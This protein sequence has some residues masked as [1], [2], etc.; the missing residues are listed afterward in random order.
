M[1]KFTRHKNEKGTA[2]DIQG[3]RTMKDI[4][5]STIHEGRFPTVTEMSFSYFIK[6]S[7]IITLPDRKDCTI[8]SI[9]SKTTLIHSCVGVTRS[10]PPTYKKGTFIHIPLDT[11][12]VSIFKISYFAS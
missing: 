8:P 1:K 2:I 7:Y 9:W 11:S 3:L 10:D 12:I 5:I 6:I 4:D